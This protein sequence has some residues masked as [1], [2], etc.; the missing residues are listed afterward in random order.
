MNSC[1]TNTV[2]APPRRRLLQNLGDE[3]QAQAAIDAVAQVFNID[4]LEK[5]EGHRLQ[6]LWQREDRLATVELFVL[7]SALLDLQARYPD[8][9]RLTAKKIRKDKSGHG[10]LTEIIAYGQLDPIA[11]ILKPA[12][13]GCPGYDFSVEFGNGM[14]DFISVKNHDVSSFEEEFRSHARRLRAAWIERLK[15]ERANLSLQV[16]GLQPL[17]RE[18]FDLAIAHISDRLDLGARGAVQVSPS[19]HLAIRPLHIPLNQLSL[20][21]TSDLIVITAPAPD[22]EQ[23]RFRKNIISAASKMKKH[24]RQH[25]ASCNVIYMRVHVNAD[26]DYLVSVAENLLNEDGIGFDLIVFYQPAYVRDDKG[27]SLLNNSF[28]MA[29]GPKFLQTLGERPRYA[30]HLPIGSV[31]F[32][33]APVRFVQDGELSSHLPPNSYIFQQGDIYVLAANEGHSQTINICSPAPGI[34]EHAIFRIQG[35]EIELASKV[36]ALTDDLLIV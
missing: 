15:R 8:W 16:V 32:S 3:T 20:G 36:T 35:R 7:G 33:S 23:I 6:T 22:A 29:V 2:K 34:R 11:G 31:S 5:N 17:L 14:T 1:Y 13:V 25:R 4:W 24:T 9:L 18:D 12:E 27:A 21:H 10:F 26:L 30:F 28:R 19:V